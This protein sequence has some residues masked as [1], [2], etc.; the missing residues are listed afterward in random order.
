MLRALRSVQSGARARS[1][2]MRLALVHLGH[3]SKTAT[4]TSTVRHF[5][6]DATASLEKFAK[7]EDTGESAAEDLKLLNICI[8]IRKGAR[9]EGECG[10]NDRCGRYA[11]TSPSLSKMR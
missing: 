9:I 7:G 8:G 1:L 10:R 3:Y 4:F 5:L 6:G 11:D 2:V